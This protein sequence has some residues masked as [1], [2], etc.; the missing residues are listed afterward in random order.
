[1]CDAP[2]VSQF[3]SQRSPAAIVPQGHIHHQLGEGEPQDPLKIWVTIYEGVKSL[4]LG[5]LLLQL[6]RMSKKH[7][8]RQKI[9][10]LHLPKNSKC[11]QNFYYRKTVQK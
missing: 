2:D 10:L 4:T 11:N 8:W 6:C 1:M 9:A 3:D 7:S 5:F